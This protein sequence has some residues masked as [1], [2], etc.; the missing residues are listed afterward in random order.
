VSEIVKPRESEKRR[1]YPS[2]MTDEQWQL[3]APFLSREPGGPGRP[4]KWEL[5]L[6]VNAIL[7]LL[8]TGCQWRALPNDFPAPSS[9]RYWFDKWTRDGTWERLNRC[10]VEQARRAAGREATPSAA[11][12]DSQS[13]KTTEVGGDRGVDGFKKVKGRKRHLLTDTAGF[14]LGVVVDVAS[15][16]DAEGGEFLLAFF[17]RSLPRLTK[18]WADGAYGDL[19]AYA[20]ELGLEL[21]ITKKAEGQRGFVVIARR[22]VIERSIAWLNRNRRLS[23]DY[24]REPLYSE[25]ML[26][27]ASIRLLMNRLRPDKN[28]PAPYQSKLHLKSAA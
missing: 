3:I 4:M 16:T 9:V 7:Y 23:K 5:R 15:L 27:L 1:A 11:L 14:L 24:E 10:L 25:A 19:D 2:D 20:K 22:W 21:E 18:L 28:R 12:L 17:S 8:Y 13:V 26:Y 6:I